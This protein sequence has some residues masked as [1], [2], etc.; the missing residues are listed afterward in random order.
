MAFGIVV[1]LV[2]DLVVELVINI[3]NILR[4]LVFFGFSIKQV[5]SEKNSKNHVLIYSIILYNHI[6]KW[7]ITQL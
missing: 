3:I 2:V 6:K 5:P 7:S 4:F 1:N